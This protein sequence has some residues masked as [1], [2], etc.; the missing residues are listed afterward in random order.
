MQLTLITGV[1]GSG[2]TVALR[3]VED[4]GFFCVDNVPLEL[5]TN[6]ISWYKN[7][8]GFDLNKLAISVDIRANLDLNTIYPFLDKIKNQ[9]IELKILFLETKNEVLIKRFSETRRVHPLLKNNITLPNALKLERK[10]LYPFKAESLVLDTSFML[11]KDL[12]KYVYEWMD[13]KGLFNIVFETFGFKYGIPVDLDFLFDVR[14]LP[15]PYYRDNLR[16]LTGF[17]LKVQKFLSVN[18]DVIDMIQSISN[19]LDKWV[20]KILKTTKNNLVIGIGCTGGVHRSVYVSL[21]LKK[22]FE[23]KYPISL[24][25][26][27]LKKS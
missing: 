25:H 19:F 16:N 2:K 26:R 23:K 20:D 24:R 12:K 9:G 17:D 11:S 15:N 10:I 1:S 3:A 21:E 8:E 7:Q 14:C 27:C 18:K 4:L 5:I 6:L 13:Y 22:I